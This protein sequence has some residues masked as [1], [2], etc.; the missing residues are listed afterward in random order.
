[1]DY[2]CVCV[3]IPFDLIYL[4]LNVQAETDLASKLL[5]IAFPPLS[6]T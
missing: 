5:F 6:P 3:F 1:M 2:L 4:G